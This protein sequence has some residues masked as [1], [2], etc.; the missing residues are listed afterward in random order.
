[1]NLCLDEDLEFGI[2]VAISFTTNVLL[3][4]RRNGL[5]SSLLGR[6]RF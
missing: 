5:D 2:V 3:V 6:A 1:M 4:Y